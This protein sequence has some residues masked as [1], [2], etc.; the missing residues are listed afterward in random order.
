MA[1]AG[2]AAAAAPAAPPPSSPPAPAGALAAAGAPALLESWD[3][4]VT[5]LRER[6]WTNHA[7]TAVL[8]RDRRGRTVDDDLDEWVATP[9]V[10]GSLRSAR[11]TAESRL[12][13]GD[14]TAASAALARALP[15]RT[16]W[17][18][19]LELVEYY[20]G[21]NTTLAV[22]REEWERAAAR[23]PAK[24]VVESRSRLEALEAARGAHMLRTAT[25][26][27][28]RAD[29]LNLGRLY[30]ADRARWVRLAAPAAVSG[31]LPA[32]RANAHACAGAVIGADEA[33]AAATRTPLLAPPTLAAD[34]FYPNGARAFGQWGNVRLKLAVAA[35]GCPVRATV[36]GSSGARLLDEAALDW[37]E[38]ARFRPA[39]VR[40]KARS[41][42]ATVEVRFSLGGETVAPDSAAAPPPAPAI[43]VEPVVVLAGVRLGTTRRELLK[44]KGPPLEK[45]GAAWTY[46]SLAPAPVGRITVSFD[47]SFDPDDDRV[48][49][50]EYFGS[51]VN[52]PPELPAVVETPCADLIARFGP[53][54]TLATLKAEA[55]QL[56]F[57]NGVA[58][59]CANNRAVSVG[60]LDLERLA[61][62][63]QVSA[64]VLAE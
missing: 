59:V 47:A 16:E 54:A 56:V 52:A 62:L 15:A 5:T 30:N 23:V 61:P 13:A 39:L 27:Q 14:G 48:V 44:T 37:S 60:L 4:S 2:L 10:L 36:I 38:F 58:A 3:R 43:A 7:A 33:A 9:E 31:E 51:R 24:L 34:T 18:R 1:F 42:E 64:V 53:A 35:N 8:G 22:L 17:A 12:K 19:Q 20:W 11:A 50:I 32:P 21:L 25:V 46:Y 63:A 29:A 6:L 41:G 55:L 57:R 49:R 40:G 28:L 45:T 26:A